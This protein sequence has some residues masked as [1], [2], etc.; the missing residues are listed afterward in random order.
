MP[1]RVLIVDDDPSFRETAALVLEERGYQV[2]GQA[3]SVASAREAVEQLQPDALLLDVN[4]PDGDGLSL[5]EELRGVDAPQRILITSSDAWAASPQVVTRSGA[6]GF[7]PKTE[8]AV[9]DLDR[10]LHDGRGGS[11]RRKS[12]VPSG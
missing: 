3:D 10:Y 1:V 4:L 9:A 12:G 5:A 8:L 2:I 6:A 7:L 11:P